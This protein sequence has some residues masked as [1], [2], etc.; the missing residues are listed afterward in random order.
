MKLDKTLTLVFAGFGGQ[1]VLTAGRIISDMALMDG[2]NATWLPAYGFAVRGGKANCVVKL[3]AGEIGSP[4]LETIDLL[5]AMNVPSLEFLAQANPGACV[6]VNSDLVRP[7]E[8]ALTGREDLKVVFVPCD[9][10]ARAANNP[11]AANIVSVGAAVRGL[12][13]FHAETAVAALK[14][15]F[16]S[17]GKGRFNDANVA[18]FMSGY[19]CGGKAGEGE[20]V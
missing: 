17:K 2:I 9:S 4:C 11:K 6:I 20:C 19:R 1:G 18:A 12:E 10:L 3:S 5:V 15:F 8:P 16:E 7:D 14:E 13:D